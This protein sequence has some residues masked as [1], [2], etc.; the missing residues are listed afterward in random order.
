MEINIDAELIKSIIS[1]GIW[2]VAACIFLLLVYHWA[3]VEKFITFFRILYLDII[4]SGNSE[5]LRLSI[6]SDMNS[7]INDIDN[8][9]PGLFDKAIK[10]EWLKEGNDHANLDKRGIF[11]RIKEDKDV[12]KLLL[13]SINCLFE[14]TLL[15]KSRPYI[16]GHIFESIKLVLLEKILSFS[17]YRSAM[18]LFRSD[19]YNPIVKNN[20]SIAQV[21]GQLE[22]LDNQGLF[23]RIFLRECNELANVV[24]IGHES[25]KPKWDL[26]NFLDFTTNLLKSLDNKGVRSDFEFS[27]ASLNI[28]FAILADEYAWATRGLEFYKKRTRLSIRRGGSVIYIIALGSTNIKIANSLGLWLQNQ[29]YVADKFVSHYKLIIGRRNNISA[30][31][32]RCDVKAQAISHVVD[33]N[34]VNKDIHINDK[35]L[36]STI[37]SVIRDTDI[38]IIKSAWIKG[39]L[40]QVVVHSKNPAKNVMQICIGKGGVN[41]KEINRLV[42]DYVKF[43]EWSSDLK[44]AIE[45]NLDTHEHSDVININL[46]PANRLAYISVKS[47]KAIRELVGN[48]E[49]NLQIAEALTEYSIE[50]YIDPKSELIHLLTRTIPEILNADIKIENIVILAGQEIRVLVFSTNIKNPDKICAGYME[51]LKSQITGSEKLYFCSKHLDKKD[52]IICSLYPLRKE[53]VIEIIEETP[54]KYIV[55][56]KDRKLMA[57]AIGTD[58]AHVRAASKL[59]DIWIELATPDEITV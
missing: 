54:S 25:S 3:K 14:R 52:T 13:K 50:I 48:E 4:K 47:T 49:K 5:S 51:Q 43:I 37:M 45:S 32:I 29:G 31:C 17:R 20:K 42:G 6:Q 30:V 35:S 8:E 38:E 9:V 34:I 16:H 33:G 39:Y 59:L 41:G 24:G 21:L 15:V 19:Q 7:A 18:I 57:I 55:V 23:T 27:S 12:D 28:A 44:I 46:D 1:R 53:D 10:I 2:P 58:G 56:V 26:S 36:H 11:I 22:Y 40:A